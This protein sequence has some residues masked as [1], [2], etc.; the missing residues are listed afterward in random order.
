MSPRI[1][2][3][4]MR[5][6]HTIYSLWSSALIP[7][8]KWAACLGWMLGFS[9]ITG[10]SVCTP[11]KKYVAEAESAASEVEVAVRATR[12]WQPDIP[13]DIAA[14]SEAAKD[15]VVLKKGDQLLQTVRSQTSLR[16]FLLSCKAVGVE[17][18]SLA[19]SAGTPAVREA[20]EAFGIALESHQQELESAMLMSAASSSG[21]LSSSGAISSAVGA[22]IEG[23]FVGESAR[24][25]YRDASERSAAA[26]KL[27]N[28]RYSGQFPVLNL[29]N[30]TDN[31]AGETAVIRGG[32]RWELYEASDTKGSQWDGSILEIQKTFPVETIESGSGVLG[33]RIRL[34]GLVRWYKNGEFRGIENFEGTYHIQ[35]REL[36]ILGQA[37]TDG[38]NL[39]RGLYTAKLSLTTRELY[40][41]QWASSADG[42][43]SVIPGVFSAKPL[44]PP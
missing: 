19:E 27:Y 15:Y 28:D 1:L 35:D 39:A 14:N 36:R 2:L 8:F 13:N 40:S 41:G 6:V 20:M 21:D 11:Y 12:A 33:E 44:S 10:L 3:T 7:R 29:L 18:K 16:G 25:R 9:S 31:A 32:D 5:M 37:T 38:S 4:S 34:T 17:F 24:E 26:V 23:Y 43:T 42:D 30:R 22:G